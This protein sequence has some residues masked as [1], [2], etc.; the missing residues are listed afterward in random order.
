MFIKYKLIVAGR[1][2]AEFFHWGCFLGE[3]MMVAQQV[4]GL[5]LFVATTTLAAYFLICSQTIGSSKSFVAFF[6][7]NSSCLFMYVFLMKAHIT[8]SGKGFLANITLEHLK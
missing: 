1:N 5:K 7:M 2:R 4:Q 6:T 3:T 8:L